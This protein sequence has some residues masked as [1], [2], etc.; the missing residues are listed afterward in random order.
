LRLDDPEL[1]RRMYASE[2][3]L[4]ARR[5]VH[6]QSVGSDAPG[7]VFQA[8]AE[9]APSRVLE[10]GCGMGQLAQRL[11]EELTAAVIAIDQSP[12]MVE[13]TR[14]RGVD[15]RVGDVQALPFGASEFDVVVAAW[16]LYHVPDLHRALDEIVRVLRPSGRLVAAT[17]RRDHMREFWEF[18]GVDHRPAEGFDPE[19]AEELLRERFS[20][21][22]IRDAAG[23]LTFDDREAVRA[24][25]RSSPRYLERADDVPELD[26]P[27]LVRRRAVVIA[28]DR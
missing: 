28:A 24:Y 20:R 19:D 12:R 6:G 8:V 16:M 21:V 5:A 15:A 26:A 7:M 9:V 17:N 18:V 1:V 10:V 23:T 4:A 11:H 2:A 22:E 3:G 13:L 14:E 25:L 27:L